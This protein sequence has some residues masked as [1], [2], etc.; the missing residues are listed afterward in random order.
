MK[1]RALL[2][3]LAVFAASSAARAED[4]AEGRPDGKPEIGV[5]FEGGSGVAL[6]GGDGYMVVQRARTELYLGGTLKLE[7]LPN[8][9]FSVA[10]VADVEPRIALGI[11]GQWGFWANK[12]LLFEAG[13]SAF[14]VP[15]TLFGVTGGMRVRVALGKTFSLLPGVKFNG[16]FAGSDL[17]N[18][19]VI[20][21]GMLVLGIHAE[22]F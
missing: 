17:P 7:E 2:V 12:S 13:P 9:E 15:E 22:I 20:V 10:L 5:F 6:G 3:A 18:N 4:K 1:I 8:Q 21:S 19:G 16:Y 14:F 11:E